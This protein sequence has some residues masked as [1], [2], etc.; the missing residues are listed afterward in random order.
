MCTSYSIKL[1]T[2]NSGRLLPAGDH[3]ICVL[4]ESILEI[5]VALALENTTR[6]I[7]HHFFIPDELI[8]LLLLSL[9]VGAISHVFLD[10]HLIAYLLL[11]V[12]ARCS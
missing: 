3:L 4:H 7:H 12:C 11:L 8:V 9:G 6:Q 2:A 5:V 1:S 10:F